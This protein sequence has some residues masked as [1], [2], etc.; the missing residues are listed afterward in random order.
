MKETIIDIG[1]VVLCDYCSEDYTTSNDTGGILFSSYAIC[2]KCAPNALKSIKGFKEEAYIQSE[3][4]EG[5]T[6]RDFVLR[7]RNGDNTI[8]IKTSNHEMEL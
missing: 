6:F 5:E 4:M 7:I 1:N 2:P 3:A 8:R